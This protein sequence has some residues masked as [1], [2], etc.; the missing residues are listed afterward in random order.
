MYKAFGDRL[1]NDAPELV[2]E[3]MLEETDTSARRNAFSFLIECKE[4]LAVEFLDDNADD[5]SCGPVAKASRNSPPERPAAATAT[6]TA[7]LP[8]WSSPSSLTRVLPLR[9]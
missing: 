9:S 5:V 8:R 6:A 3:M 4:E 1:M 2:Y 7:S